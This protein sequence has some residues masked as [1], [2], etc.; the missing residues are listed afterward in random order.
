MVPFVGF[1]SHRGC[2][3]IHSEETTANFQ[4]RPGH[5]DSRY[6]FSIGARKFVELWNVHGP[7]H[8]CAVGIGHIAAKLEK[9]GKLLQ[10]EMVKVC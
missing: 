8:H 1:H 4:L 2:S 6:R 9:L 5:T 10:M 7:A 3:R